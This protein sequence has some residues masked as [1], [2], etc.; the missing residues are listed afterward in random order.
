[1]DI[2][3]QLSYR[4]KRRTQADDHG[5]FP[6]WPRLEGMVGTMGRLSC[7]PTSQPFV[8]P[9]TAIIVDVCKKVF[10][11]GVT[12]HQNSA[13]LPSALAVVHRREWIITTS[14]LCQ[15]PQSVHCP[16]SFDLLS[17]QLG[18]INGDGLAWRG[19]VNRSVYLSTSHHFLLSFFP[20]TLNV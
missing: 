5:R 13:R 8:N 20:K 19:V 12:G 3:Q 18:D 16:R 10:P 14:Y 4:V 7:R 17:S 6:Y 11:C 2:R 1:M 15:R 9:G